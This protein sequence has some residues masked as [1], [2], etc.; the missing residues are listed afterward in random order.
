MDHSS[1]A[2]PPSLLLVDLGHDQ[3]QLFAQ[4]PITLDDVN[5]RK[6]CATMNTGEELFANLVGSWDKRPEA[7]TGLDN[8]FLARDLRP[9]LC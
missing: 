4:V 9:A 7:T 2:D 6:T 1:G 3:Q 5:L 8:L